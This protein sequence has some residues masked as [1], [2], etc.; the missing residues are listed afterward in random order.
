MIIHSILDT[1]LY[2]L[3]M[4]QAILHQHSGTEVEYKFVCRSLIPGYTKNLSRIAS[5]IDHTLWCLNDLSLTKEEYNYLLTIPFLKKSYIH[6]LRDFRFHREYVKFRISNGTI[7]L[8]IK[9]PWLYTILFEIPLLATISEAYSSCQ[10][11]ESYEGIGMRRLNK[12]ISIA[13]ENDLKFSDFGTRR[14]FSFS[15]QQEVL[16]KLI[17]ADCGLVG[18]SNVH[19][20]RTLGIKSI[21]TMAHE[22]IMAHQRIKSGLDEHQRNAFENW[23]QEY[24]GDLG[25]A[26]T[27]TIG[28]DAFC[29]DFDLYF[30]KL[31]DGVRHDSGCPYEFTKKIINHY[32]SKKIDPKTKLVVYSDGLTFEKMVDLK[33]TFSDQINIGFGIGTNLTNDVGIEPLSIVIKL[34]NC[35][36]QPVAK[37]SDSP[38]K[39]MCEDEEFVKSLRSIFNK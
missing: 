29:N 36:D 13:K 27:D 7:D 32:K 23:A 6:F 31:F 17:E 22:W 25:I 11:N 4:Q 39:T 24:R 19:F 15:W 34:I 5:E 18:T 28:V 10:N 33:N 3:T 20:A 8:R 37:L 14:R 35:N 9:G 38:E 12:K 2:K 16:K 21:G 30:S 26:L 1:D